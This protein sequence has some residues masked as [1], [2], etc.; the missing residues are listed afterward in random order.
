VSVA[1]VS[2]VGATPGGVMMMERD[3]WSPYVASKFPTK[4]SSC[5]FCLS[6]TRAASV[7]VSSC[8]FA[9]LTSARSERA[10]AI[11]ASRST[12]VCSAFGCSVVRIGDSKA[13]RPAEPP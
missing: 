2:L 8:V 6:A 4:F 10:V 12:A 7:S 13:G 1:N 5:L 11:A 3:V 9:F